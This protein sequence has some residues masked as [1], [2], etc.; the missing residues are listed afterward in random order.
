MWFPGSISHSNTITANTTFTVTKVTSSQNCER[1]SGFTNASHTVPVNQLPTYTTTSP[2]QVCS[3]APFTFVA[4]PNIVG[5]TLSWSRA[6]QPG[7]SNPAASGSGLSF[8]ENLN[9][10][11][12]GNPGF[13]SP[14]TSL[15]IMVVV[16][17]HFLM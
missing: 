5:T 16:P 4:V 14:T 12:S 7:I 3:G 9:S 2:D 15:S 10:T 6:V 8:T 17:T 1:T 13:P 11:Q